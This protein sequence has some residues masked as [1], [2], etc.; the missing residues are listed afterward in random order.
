M[1]PRRQS[2]VVLAAVAA[3]ASASAGTGSPDLV[4]ESAHLSPEPGVPG[5][6]MEL[7]AVVVNKGQAAAGPSRLRAC[8]DVDV[9]FC[10]AE[11]VVPA[12]AVGQRAT[13]R[14]TLAAAATKGRAAEHP[15][16]FIARADVAGTV[17]ESIE[18][19]NATPSSPAFIVEPKRGLAP[20]INEEDERAVFHDGATVSSSKFSYGPNGAPSFPRTGPR[21][22]PERDPEVVRTQ[23]H[24]KV[25]EQAAA[26]GP[27]G[28]I[29]VIVH[30]GSR[31]VPFPRLPD[32]NPA[33]PRLSTA[34]GRV[35]AQRVATFEAVRRERRQA[36]APLMNSVT[37][38]GGRV[39][40]F[41]VLASAFRATIPVKSLDALATDSRIRNIEPVKGGEAPPNHDEVEEAIDLIGTDQFF[42]IGATGAGWSIGLLDTGVRSTHALLSSPDRIGL[43]RDCVFGNNDCLD[44]GNVNYNASD[45]C[46]HGTS[47]AGILVGNSNLGASFRGVTAAEVDSFDVYDIS[48]FLDT[49]AVLN[50][51]D[52][53]IVWGD[54]VIV[55]EMQ[56]SQSHTGS[57]ADAADNAFDSG[58]LVIAAN[59]NNGPG[60]G[61]VDSPA[62]AHKAIGIGAFDLVSGTSYSVQSRGPT[63]DNRI[64]PD[65]RFPN[66]S[67]TAGDASDTDT[68]V[69]TGTSGA[70]PYGGGAGMVLVDQSQNIGWSTDPGRIYSMLIAFGNLQD[71]FGNIS[72]AGDVSVGLSSDKWVRGTRS[73]TNNDVD[74]V[75]FDIDSNDTCIEAAIWWPEGVTWHNDIDL[76]IDNPSGVQQGGS[77]EV[78]SVFERIRLNAPFSAT[79]T[80][81]L[82]IEGYSVKAAATPETVYYFAHVC[83]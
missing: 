18:N 39:G 49:S 21:T 76:Y 34:N 37:Q 78:D 62:S 38:K 4:V 20:V 59:G 23:V 8:E 81:K 46:A 70:T 77:I 3:I 36:L 2:I 63:G 64:K 44:T 13:V 69:F 72:G 48:C 82:R 29:E 45:N 55:A 30:A 61:T 9:A 15:R 6:P 79:G 53:A 26:A 33:E 60:S 50:G 14:A 56:S 27:N 66:N 74:T 28:Q 19:N 24:P 83:D 80:W 22:K 67:E 7:S 43:F 31:D 10:T 41:F 57:I 11:A 71:P 25:R 75:D 42:S 58:S 68:S 35:L 5:E 12:L 1:H 65:V 73:I 40:N 54:K 47:S 52:R 51:F 16:I 32:L 17:R